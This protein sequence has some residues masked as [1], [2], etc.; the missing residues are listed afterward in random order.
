MR[1]ILWLCFFFFMPVSFANQNVLL[2]QM[3]HIE[4]SQASHD[5]FKTHQLLF[6]FASTCPHC[7]KAA[8]HLKTW[9]DT[10]KAGVIA[11]SF[12][13]QPLPEFPHVFEVSDAL[14]QTAYSGQPITTPALFMM[15]TETNQLYPAMMG[16]W[17]LSELEHRLRALIEKIERY[18]G[19]QG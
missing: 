19:G 11:V 6:F 18:E 10:Y 3:E 4:N 8:P 13:R 2:Q 1:R 14:I 5:F 9:A 15:N 16:E 12:D 7:H 17:T